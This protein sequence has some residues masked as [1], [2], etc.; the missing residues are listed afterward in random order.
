MANNYGLMKAQV[1]S[2]SSF[3]LEALTISSKW[4]VGVEREEREKKQEKKKRVTEYKKTR[5]LPEQKMFL[6]T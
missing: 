2:V 6:N 4:R 5:R 3:S 1:N